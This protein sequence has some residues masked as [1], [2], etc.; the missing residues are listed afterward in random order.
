MNAVKLCKF[1]ARVSGELTKSNHFSPLTTGY[2][3]CTDSN[4]SLP[5]CQPFLLPLRNFSLKSSI[6][7]LNINQIH[8]T[9]VK[10]QILAVKSGNVLKAQLLL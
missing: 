10:L 8:S 7:V 6:L 4:L 5:A 2:R 3:P 1:T 9:A